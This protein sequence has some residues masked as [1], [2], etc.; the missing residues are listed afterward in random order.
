MKWGNPVNTGSFGC[1][2]L[3]S[4]CSRHHLRHQFIQLNMKKKTRYYTDEFPVLDFTAILKIENI[5]GKTSC[6]NQTGE[7][8][9]FNWLINND[10]VTVNYFSQGHK[11]EHGVSIIRQKANYGGERLFVLCPCCRTKRKKL[12]IRNKR[13]A[14]SGCQ[15]LHCRSQSQSRQ[16]RRFNKLDRILNRVN[17]FGFRFDGYS[18]P[19]GQHWRNYYEI[20]NQIQTLQKSLI[21]DVSKKFGVDMSGYF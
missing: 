7:L 9:S 12:Y 4:S 11:H 17:N 1:L 15:S 8:W 5:S 10:K 6:S 3:I 14:C 2:V 20:D 18:K 16:Q 13:I 21:N 19:K